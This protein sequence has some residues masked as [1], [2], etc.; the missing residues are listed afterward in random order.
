[1][2]LESLVALLKREIQAISLD[3]IPAATISD[4]ARLL[5]DLGLDSL[6]YASL[7]LSGQEALGVA[8]DED[9]VD[10]RMVATVRDLATLL[11]TSRVV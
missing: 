3:Q 2:E 4:D 6:D 9:N 8:V 11:H 5:A 1:M 7:M 10:W